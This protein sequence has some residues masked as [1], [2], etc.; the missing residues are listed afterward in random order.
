M[1]TY[2]V[3]IAS[4]A[5]GNIYSVVTYPEEYGKNGSWNTFQHK[6]KIEGKRKT[7][8]IERLSRQRAEDYIKQLEA[9]GYERYEDPEI[10]ELA[11]LMGEMY[12]NTGKEINLPKK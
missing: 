2:E 12:K 6:Y 3:K 4:T 9:E 5:S 10:S 11:E 1:K 8:K 7:G